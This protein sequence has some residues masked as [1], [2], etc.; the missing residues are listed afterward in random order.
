MALSRAS[1]RQ[2]PDCLRRIGM[3]MGESSQVPWDIP[4]MDSIGVL[5]AIYAVPPAELRR[6]VD[7]AQPKALIL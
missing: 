6:T 5:G 7:D 3:L 2:K 1:N 4:P